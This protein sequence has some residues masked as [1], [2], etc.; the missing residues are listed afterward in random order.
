MRR[1]IT[2]LIA[3][4]AMAGITAPVASAQTGVEPVD[5]VVR[6]AQTVIKSLS[7]G[8]ESPHKYACEENHPVVQDMI[9]GVRDSLKTRFPDYVTML[10]RGFA[11][12]LDA[13][14]AQSL[15]EGHWLNPDFLEDGHIMDPKYPEGILVDKWN[16]PIGVM[17]ITDHPNQPGPDMYVAEDG[18]PCNAW[19][20]H[21]ETAADTYWYLYKYLW[22]DAIENGELEPEPRSPDLMHVWAY[23]DYKYQ[24]SH[25]TPPAS[26]LPG[27]PSP[28]EIPDIIGGPRVPTGPI[29]PIPPTTKR[30]GDL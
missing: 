18:T 10:A 6:S 13:P 3:G 14:L 24:W 27:D 26:E 17:F 4:M 16:R 20:Y 2:A 29:P 19:H 5:T 25:A 12:Y 15:G 7:G 1:T 11:P 28:E 8:V 9:N 30:L 21:T 22:S 23:G